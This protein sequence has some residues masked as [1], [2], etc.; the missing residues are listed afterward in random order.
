[1]K[2]YQKSSFSYYKI[3]LQFLILFGFLTFNSFLAQDNH[4]IQ[5]NGG[6]LFP[7]SADNGF[8]TSI[9]YNYLCSDALGLYISLGYAAWDKNQVI[10]M[11]D[12]STIQKETRFVSY[13]SDNHIVIPLFVGT[14]IYLPE[15]KIFKAFVNIE[16]GYSYFS[17]NS[18]D[19]VREVDPTTGVVLSYYVDQSTK[20]EISTNLFGIGFG[21]GLSHQFINGPNL[22]LAYKINSSLSS[23]EF[24]L[25]GEE[26]TS[27]TLYIGLELNI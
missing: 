11:E 17:Y 5:L 26:S 12:F 8:S 18:Y 1:M 19:N 6:I 14:K 27:S 3:K 4:S 10:F 7:R 16:I 24:S 13:D 15:T 2:C 23:S 20:K 21:G 25:F 9:Q 22:I